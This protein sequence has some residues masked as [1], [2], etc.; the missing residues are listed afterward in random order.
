[1]GLLIGLAHDPKF[2]DTDKNYFIRGL[3]L[4]LIVS[5]TN[6][7]STEFRERPS[8]FAGVAYAPIIDLA[9]TG[10][11]KAGFEQVHTYLKWLY[12]TMVFLVDIRMFCFVKNI[13]IVM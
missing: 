5:L 2:I 13:D 10:I 12:R 3:V 4:G 9:A 8:F 6:T 1:M 7:S 11:G